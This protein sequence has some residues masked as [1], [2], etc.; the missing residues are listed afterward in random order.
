MMEQVY[1]A[2]RGGQIVKVYDRVMRVE[3][4]RYPAIRVVQEVGPDPA[5]GQQAVL[6]TTEMIADQILVNL[7]PG[8]TLDQV[9]QATGVPLT[10]RRVLPGTGTLV[11]AFAVSSPGEV[12]AVRAEVAR[13][14]ALVNFAEPD[15]IVRA[16]ATPN[17]PKYT[18]G[19]LWGMHNTGQNAGTADADTDAPEG[20]DTRTSALATIA[21]GRSGPNISVDGPNDL[22]IAVV[23][24]GV[25]YTH[26]DIAANMWKNP[27]ES[28]GGKETNGIDDDANGV[29][30]DVH[31]V[32]AVAGTGD[33]MDDQYHGTHCAGTIAGVGNNGKGVTG[34]AWQAKIAACKF[35]A[36]DGSGANS[37]AS[38]ALW[39]AW[40]QAGADVI[41]CSWGGGSESTEVT[42]Q[43][44]AAGKNGA[45]VVIAAGNNS[46]D[47][48][49][50]G[51]Y[52]AVSQADNIVTVASTTRTDARSSFSNYNYGWCNVGAPGSDITSLGNKN[53]SDYSVLSGTSMATPLTAGI[54]GLLRAQFPNETYGQI[55]NRL[56][57][58]VDAISALSGLVQ[59]GGRVNLQKSLATTSDAPLNDSFSSAWTIPASVPRS[60]RT[61]NFA[62]TAEAGEPAHGGA[63]ANKTVWYKWTAPATATY[64]V[65]T[66][67][68]AYNTFTAGTP[69]TYGTAALDTTLGVY[70]G[71]AVNSLSTVAQNNDYDAAGTLMP[72]SRTSFAATSG[73][74]YY[75]AVGTAPS[76][77]VQEGLIILSISQP[78]ANDTFAS[79]TNISSVP[80]S[81]NTSNLNAL[82][83]TGEPKLHRA[84]VSDD[85]PGDPTLQNNLNTT[86]PDKRGQPD[87]GGASVWWKWTPA[88]TG[89]YV[90]STNGSMIDTMMGIYTGSTFNALALVAEND[91]I[92]LIRMG[93]ENVY[94]SFSSI[95]RTFTAGTTYYIQVDGF[96]GRQGEVTLSISVPPAN[97]N[98][99]NA[100][101]VTGNLW[102]TTVSNVGASFE[103]GEPLHAGEYGGVSV[104]FKW[105]AP[106]TQDYQLTLP[107]STITTALAVY[108]SSNPAAPTVGGLTEVVSNSTPI[109]GSNVRLTTTAGQTYFIAVDGVNGRQSATMQLDLSST[110]GALLN[111]R[112]ADR[113]RLLGTSASVGSTTSGA[114]FETGEPDFYGSSSQRS[115][116]WT[117]TAPA[118]G[119]VTFTTQYSAYNA[120]LGVYTGSAVNAL[121]L[122][123]S[124][125]P[126]AGQSSSDYGRVTFTATR[127][128]T[129][130]IGVFG[131]A[132]YCGNCMLN[133]SMA[134][135]NA[136]PK[137]ESATLSASTIFADQSVSVSSVITSDAESNPVTV[138]YQWQSSTDG[139][140]WSDAAGK[141]S[142]M[143][144][145]ADA[146]AGLF[147]RCRISPSDATGDGN[148]FYT[149]DVAVQRRPVQL[150]RDGQTYSFS[151]GLPIEGASA[152]AKRGIIINEFSKTDNASASDTGS[153]NGEW[154][155]LLTLRDVNL[156][157]Y[158]LGNVFASIRFLDVALWQNV[159][160]GTL[161]VIYNPTSKSVIVPADD[162]DPSDGRIVVSGQNAT[163]FDNGNSFAPAFPKL[164]G[165]G[166]VG[167]D[168]AGTGARIVLSRAFVGTVD[169]ISY[170]NLAHLGGDAQF[171]RNPHLPAT[172]PV[173]KTYRYTGASEDACESTGNWEIGNADANFATPGQ[174]NNQAQIE[175]IAKL[176]APAPQ[177]RFAAGSSV[178]SGLT[179]NSTTGEI[180]G[181]VNAP[182]GGLHTLLVERYAAGTPTTS[183]TVQVLVGT[184]ANV[185]TIA[186]GQ[187][188][189][190]TG[191]L[192]L[193]T[194]TLV[195][196]GTINTNG[197][198]LTQK[199][200]YA[201][202]AAAHGVTGSQADVLPGLGIT[203]KMAFAL[204]LDP[205]IATLD[206]LPA[207]GTAA[208]SGSDY[209]T[210]TFRRQ[211][212]SPRVN[213]IVQA[214]SDLWG[215]T[216]LNTAAQM[217]GS[218]VSIDF[219]TEEVTVR[220][221][222]ALGGANTKRFLRLKVTDNLVP[223]PAPV[224]PSATLATGLASLSWSPSSGAETYTVKR[225][226]TPGGPYTT[227]VSGLTGTTYNDASVA[228]GTTYYYVITATNTADG[229]SAASTEI[230]VT[231][232]ATWAPD[233][234]TGLTATP[235]AMQVGLTW[236]A[237]A[238]A[239]SYT[240]KRGTTSGGPYTDLATGVTGTSHNDTTAVIGTNY[241][242]V[243]TATNTGGTSANSGQVSGAVVVPVGWWKMNDTTGL[244]AT[245]SGSAGSGQNATLQNASGVTWSAGKFGNAATLDGI[246]TSNS[247]SSYFRAANNL[248]ASA[249]N[250]CTITLWVK[251]NL[252]SAGWR[253]LF[254]DRSGSVQKGIHVNNG[255][256]RI[257]NWENDNQTASSLTIPDNTWT[258]VALTVSP[259]QMKAWLRTE[260]A[261]SF[262][263]WTSATTSFTARQWQRP[264]IGGDQWNANLA[265]QL[266]DVRFYD[267]T[268]TEAELAAIYANTN[269]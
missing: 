186:A 40:E 267:R 2:E 184:S 202:W 225:S 249:V 68:S 231:T 34:V 204:N 130:Q 263:S 152:P 79:A 183:Q 211:K 248:T 237:V 31:G 157:G 205:A 138:A 255:V 19:S 48:E 16:N 269:Q 39:Y 100:A 136:L 114:A 103:D 145:A 88:V 266:D 254:Y 196:R 241:Y 1:P 146:N 58:G 245:N 135:A 210:L 57:R 243:V 59:T 28:G 27:G 140:T 220:D 101:L 97:D 47:L 233:A 121:T 164:S 214:S 119:S 55:I 268:L 24:T 65:S 158:E 94:L 25:R 18:D 234:P 129:Y 9:S 227:V 72:W 3:G 7:A 240:V 29:I 217:V 78:P 261:G 50:T 167:S 115:V 37:D 203:K 82:T 96:M 174:P 75:F 74:T 33:P 132:S 49:Q 175:W 200:S 222:L 6:K 66:K 156:V 106:S 262:S 60:L 221:T 134:P 133:L 256:L 149:S 246:G 142:A 159:P 172:L 117:W 35:L 86:F 194:G 197:Y 257:G 83:E 26:E 150:A 160:K 22:V 36:S 70:T 177:Y 148:P 53:D 41:S 76:A 107:I 176:R 206:D 17:D 251:G 127:G 244:T 44:R 8:A 215:W 43:I 236:N 67:G 109:I 122:V 93:A 209:I 80:F 10:I 151:A 181:T 128:V 212:G 87:D 81:S 30:D 180:S 116:W 69:D 195:N 224:S 199:Q 163:Y 123:A 242:Y 216:D 120:A 12:D 193:G 228:T 124:N 198:A 112:F 42:N 154:F 113:T 238:N 223:P 264:G 170:H 108:T 252:S 71:S 85:A 111:D 162:L 208:A 153:S 259:T 61:A 56:Y 260:S 91:D 247:V 173:R 235:N 192:D 189:T 137:V 64:I 92:G 45:I 14:T 102:S 190:L 90:I 52:P 265:G 118:S 20:W 258:F 226:T 84:D 147:W 105:V 229:E 178:P 165:S 99:A 131:N 141:A 161:I 187:T 15:G 155:E 182:S 139:F 171:Y 89:E 21:H 110:P 179:I 95:R 166:Y 219:A 63:A 46:A 230:S 5:T 253:G 62:A 144:P 4:R 73:T 54:V 77:T 188:F 23:D 218:P 185:F 239:T 125:T 213:Y 13:Q 250:A 32:N 201:S 11:A 38:E 207:L 143:L 191:D 232:P 51:T 104:W 169:D 168:A 98:I 126:P